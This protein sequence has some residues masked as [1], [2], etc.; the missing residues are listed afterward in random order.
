MAGSVAGQAAHEPVADVSST[1]SGLACGA[2]YQWNGDIRSARW[3]VCR[4]VPR[5]KQGRSCFNRGAM[6]MMFS[7]IIFFI[8]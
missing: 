2:V 7:L 1:G 6:R 5:S 3:L 8:S 4:R